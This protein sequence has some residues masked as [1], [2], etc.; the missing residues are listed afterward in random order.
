M[1]KEA[2][3]VVSNV[4]P[5]GRVRVIRPDVPRAAAPFSL[6]AISPSGCRPLGLPPEGGDAII[7][8]ESAQLV[9]P[10]PLG[11]VCCGTLKIAATHT[12]E[13]PQVLRTAVA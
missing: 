6:I 9:V 7:G 3:G 2:V 8:A 1:P 11:V 4:R 13:S 5:M 12:R 10:D